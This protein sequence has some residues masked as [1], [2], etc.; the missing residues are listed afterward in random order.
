MVVKPGQKESYSRTFTSADVKA[1][2]EISGDRGIHHVVPD[3]KGRVMVQGLLTACLPTKLGGDLN[4]IAAEMS[5]KFVRPV[6]V[7]ETITCEAEVVEATTAEGRQKVSMDI[8]CKNQDGKEVLL[9]KTSG[10]IRL[11]P[12]QGSQSTSL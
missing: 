10:I 4:Y 5:F 7:G 6:F 2:S 1:F 8:V 11:D 9:G 12:K 3:P